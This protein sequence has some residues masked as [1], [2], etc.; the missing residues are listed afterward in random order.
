M[1]D[2]PRP[3]TLRLAHETEPLIAEVIYGGFI[4]TSIQTWIAYQQATKPPVEAA[5]PWQD[6]SET[7][8]SAS[9]SNSED[10]ASSSAD[11]GDSSI[12]AFMPVENDD[13]QEET[14]SEAH[15]EPSADQ[16]L[17][18]PEEVAPP[19]YTTDDNLLITRGIHTAP[20]LQIRF[21]DAETEEL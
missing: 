1:Y 15:L 11:H 20:D 17:P 5:A 3:A 14:D 6:A 19:F 7:V 18:I 16:I 10:P 21:F 9:P 13:P 4:P 2:T 8:D 12:P